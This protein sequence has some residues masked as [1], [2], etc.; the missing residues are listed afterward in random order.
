MIPA[1][2]CLQIMDGKIDD[3]LFFEALVAAFVCIYIF[4]FLPELVKEWKIDKLI[5]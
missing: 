4:A 5:T 3:E 1:G 2:G